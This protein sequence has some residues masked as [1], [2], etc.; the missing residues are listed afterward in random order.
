MCDCVNFR[1]WGGI[2]IAMSS[3]IDDQLCD[4]FMQHLH[5]TQSTQ[6]TQK[7]ISWVNMLTF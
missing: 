4:L 2:S 1:I 3:M 5:H 7:I 6:N